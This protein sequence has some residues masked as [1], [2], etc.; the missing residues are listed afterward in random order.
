MNIARAAPSLRDGFLGAYDDQRARELLIEMY[1]VASDLDGDL[2]RFVSLARPFINGVRFIE[3]PDQVYVERN[4]I[5]RQQLWDGVID[6]REHSLL[7]KELKRERDQRETIAS[8]Q[9]DEFMAAYVPQ[10]RCISLRD[11]VSEQIVARVPSRGVVVRRV[12]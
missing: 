6:N 7:P 11:T 4:R 1:V 12:N 2:A 3:M 5:Y 8:G 10:A 9:K